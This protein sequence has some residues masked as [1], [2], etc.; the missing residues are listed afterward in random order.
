M[1]RC[2]RA[3]DDKLDRSIRR[4]TLIVNAQAASHRF[5]VSNACSRRAH[6]EEGQVEMLKTSDLNPSWGQ[7]GS[8]GSASRRSAA[9]QG[10][11]R[12]ST[13]YEV[14]HLQSSRVGLSP[15]RGGILWDV[16]IGGWAAVP[17]SLAALAGPMS[18][19]CRE[20]APLAATP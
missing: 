10:E 17:P 3:P 15:E 19:R 6:A 4:I 11:D 9:K 2:C 8:V 16:E 1:E 5:T 12:T 13:A 18:G 20:G 14:A 7:R